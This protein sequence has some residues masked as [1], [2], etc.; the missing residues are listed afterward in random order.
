MVWPGHDENL[1]AVAREALHCCTLRRQCTS[2]RG[3][4]RARR[5]VQRD[6]ARCRVIDGDLAKT[7]ARKIRGIHRGGGRADFHAH[8]I[9]ADPGLARECRVGA[10]H[11]VPEGFH[12]CCVCCAAGSWRKAACVCRL[13][14]H[15]HA[16][17]SLGSS[18]V[19]RLRVVV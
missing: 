12:R 2:E 15:F 8:G 14:V 10:E 7:A 11:G 19:K 1:L 5:A 17:V 9:G 16:G 3:V 4:G 13:A 18:V 6:D